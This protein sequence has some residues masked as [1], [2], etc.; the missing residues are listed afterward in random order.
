MPEMSLL[1]AKGQETRTG[2]RIMN[3]TPEYDKILD[4]QSKITPKDTGLYHRT[5]RHIANSVYGITETYKFYSRGCGKT[6]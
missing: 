3:N 5:L 1:Y 4:S 2:D 6:R